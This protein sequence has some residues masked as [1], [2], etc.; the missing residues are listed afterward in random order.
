[1][2]VCHCAGIPERCGSE[3]NTGCEQVAGLSADG[4]ADAFRRVA[5]AKFTKVQALVRLL[6]LRTTMQQHHVWAEIFSGCLA[7][8]G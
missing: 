7:G 1:M 8:N 5:A 3:R 4:L 6:V 2:A